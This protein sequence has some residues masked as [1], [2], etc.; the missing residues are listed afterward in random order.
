MGLLVGCRVMDGAMGFY[1]G[2]DD[3]LCVLVNDKIPLRI[4]WESFIQYNMWLSRWVSLGDLS[5][6]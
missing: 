1:D 2:R 3:A 5:D 6:M 4:R